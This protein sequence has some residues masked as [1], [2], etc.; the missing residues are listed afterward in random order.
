IDL[1]ALNLNQ[2]I[3]HDDYIEVGSM[4]TLHDFESHESII[5]L[6][7]GF[8]GTAVGSIMGVGFRN[9]ATVGGSI[10][11]RYS[12]SDLIT[13]L[14]TLP[15]KLIFYPFKE[16]PLESFLLSKEKVTDIL[17]HIIIEKRS[18]T[19]YFKK[20]SNSGLD[21]A[22]LNVAVFKEQGQYQI[23]IGSRPGG[24]L[25]AHEALDFLNSQP[26]VNDEV[27][28]QTANIVLDTI[29]LGSNKAA[30]EEYRKALAKAYVKRGIKEVSS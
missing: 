30:S 8:L 2:I 3:D 11:G 24:A 28:E 13:S 25:I 17:T 7:K 4:V 22:I 27:I 19:G 10:V 5:S 1:N 14:V 29:K 9:I 21:F 23:A 15:V 26:L 18:G 20:V 16:M 12:F 6:G